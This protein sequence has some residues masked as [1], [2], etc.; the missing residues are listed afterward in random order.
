MRGELE[1]DFS[2]QFMEQTLGL[3]EQLRS[4]ALHEEAL[5]EELVEVSARCELERQAEVEGLQEEIEGLQREVQGLEAL[6]EEREMELTT[7]LT[8]TR[9]MYECETASLRQQLRD[10]GPVDQQL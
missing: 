10:Q 2:R 6:M 1:E 9:F 7:Q 8:E 5:Q 4:R 3:Q